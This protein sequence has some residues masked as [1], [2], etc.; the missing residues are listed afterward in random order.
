MPKDFNPP[1][2]ALVDEMI[3]SLPNVVRGQ[4]M[5][6]PAYKIAG[7]HFGYLG[8]AGLILKVPPDLE[9]RLLERPEVIP[10][11]PSASGKP[12]RGW[13]EIRHSE[14]ARYADELDHVLAALN[15][16]LALAQTPKKK[17]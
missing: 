2:R 5:G 12:M 13:V 17:L 10:F 11:N 6:W 15:Y 4:M 7:K 9:A 3:L 1:H 16:V 14:P 8:E